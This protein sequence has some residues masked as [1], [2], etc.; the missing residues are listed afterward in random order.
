MSQHTAEARTA[1]QIAVES[2]LIKIIVGGCT[3]STKTPELRYHDSRCHFRLASEAMQLLD[4][5]SPAST[6]TSPSGDGGKGEKTLD[7]D[8][9]F[10]ANAQ[11]AQAMVNVAHGVPAFDP[12]QP[13]DAERMACGERF[14]WGG[15]PTMC[16]RC[17]NPHHACDRGMHDPQPLPQAHRGR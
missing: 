17:K 10:A 11:D 2:K 6:P 3:C 9:F 7:A 16:M 5:F 1:L 14:G 15:V 12:N 4:G 8:A 13:C